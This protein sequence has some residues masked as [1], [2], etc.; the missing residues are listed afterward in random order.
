MR[1]RAQAFR[2]PKHGNSEEE[3]EDAC[4]P[5]RHGERELRVFRCAVADGAT[6]ASFAGLW[7][8]LLVR[9]YCRGELSGDRLEA[10]LSA[11][12]DSWRNRVATRPLPWYAEEKLRSGAFAAL[13]GLTLTT[14][15]N[16]FSWRA[17]AVGDSCIFHLR[18]GTLLDAFP[19]ASAEDFNNRPHLL[20]SNA[21]LNGSLDQHL[22]RARGPAEPGDV[23]L[24]MTDALA[25]WALGCGDD[26]IP[27][28]PPGHNGSIGP[29]LSGEDRAAAR[30][31]RTLT[32][33]NHQTPW[34]ILHSLRNDTEFGALIHALRC[35]HTLRN[36]DVTLLRL[37]LR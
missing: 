6:E 2:L 3:Y 1:V 31:P 11:L 8:D 33:P 26:S 22:K 37:E 9:A 34:E 32:A 13:A 4:W 35:A 36:D 27:L 28:S 7:A 18:G 30:Q 29:P 24:L 16:G 20:G 10:T 25:A 12:G 5:M 23:F 19:L 15:R 14:T 17:L 21:G